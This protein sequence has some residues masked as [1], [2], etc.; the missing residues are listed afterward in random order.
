MTHL[1]LEQAAQRLDELEV[2]VVGKTTDVVV[3]LDPRRVLRARLDDIWVQRP[4]HEEPRVRKPAGRFLEHADEELAD[5]LALDFRVGDAGEALEEP[6]R[7]LHVHELDALVAV[8]RVD[9]LLALA[10]P[11]EPGVDVDAGELRA[12]RLVHDRGRDR[13]VDATGQTADHALAADLRA[14]RVDRSL[15]DRRHRPRRP[16]LAYREQELLQHLLPARRVRDLGM[17]LHAVDAPDFVLEHRGGRVGRARRHVEAVG[18]PSDGVE[19]RHP[20]GLL[21]RRPL[22]EDH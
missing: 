10:R 2:H 17:E 21:A 4:L 8:E 6:V 22:T 18:R 3:A 20:H 15:D 12:H 19:V 9:D 11:H 7:R 13:G 5:R 14:D 1:V 16:A